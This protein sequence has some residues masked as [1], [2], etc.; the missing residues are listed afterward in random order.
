[1]FEHFVQAQD[2]VYAD[3]LREL[4][5]GRKQ[6]HWMWF[7]FP[8]IA[9]LGASA[10]AARYALADLDEARAYLAD[11][12]VGARLCECVAL[13]NAINGRT[14]HEIF[15]APDDLKFRSCLTLFLLATGE[16]VFR[17]GLDKFYGGERDPLTERLAC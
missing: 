1:M 15:G 8:Q 4:R 5:A 9:G 10:M 13:V 6:S 16:S 7:V 14:A 17:D 12:I 3:V 11:A 2:R